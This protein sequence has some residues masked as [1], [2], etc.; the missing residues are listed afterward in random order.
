MYAS[1]KVSVRWNHNQNF[2]TFSNFL[3]LLAVQK[4]CEMFFGHSVFSWRLLSLVLLKLSFSVWLVTF[5][6]WR[7][8]GILSN[9]IKCCMQQY[10]IYMIIYSMLSFP[11]IFAYVVLVFKHECIVM[12]KHLLLV[13]IFNNLNSW[14]LFFCVLYGF[15]L[16]TMSKVFSYFANTFTRWI[17]YL[18]YALKLYQI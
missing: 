15:K 18:R 5:S 12:N 8:V 7:S 10:L 13:R 16:V 11:M 14:M 17:F 9:R 6:N 4:L 2:K 3:W 1:K